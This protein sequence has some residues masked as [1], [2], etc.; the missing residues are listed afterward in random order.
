MARCVSCQT[1]QLYSDTLCALAADARL[2]DPKS[3]NAI[4]DFFEG[5]GDHIFTEILKLFGRQFV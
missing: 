2:T 5:L 3:I 1:R 4:A